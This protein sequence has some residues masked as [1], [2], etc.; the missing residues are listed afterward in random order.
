[1]GAGGCEDGSMLIA[2]EASSASH[3][4]DAACEIEEIGNAVFCSG[5]AETSLQGMLEPWVSG[6]LRG[7]TDKKASADRRVGFD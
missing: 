4:G 1:M 6:R 5:H 2:E 7:K 3:E